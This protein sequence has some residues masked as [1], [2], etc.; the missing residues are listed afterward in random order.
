MC[1]TVC[2]GGNGGG[3]LAPA[4]PI[5]DIAWRCILQS[6]VGGCEN[7]PRGRVEIDNRNVANVVT[8][9]DNNGSS[10]TSIYTHYSWT[11]VIFRLFI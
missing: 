11:L 9:Y 7:Q 8:S 6:N 2:V 1:Y 3:L 4:Q 10:E 5:L